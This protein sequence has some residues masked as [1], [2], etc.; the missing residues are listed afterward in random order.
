MPEFTSQMAFKNPFRRTEKQNPTMEN[1]T[2]KNETNTTEEQETATERTAETASA[3]TPSAQLT[4]SETLRAELDLLRAEHQATHDKHLRLFAEFDNFRKRTAKEKLELLQ[5]G[6][7]S[8]LRSILPVLDDLD[9]A[10]VNNDTVQDLAAMREGFR[11]IQQKLQSTLS[12]QGL[13]VLPD[14]KGEFFDTDKHEA[15][16]KAPA[17]TPDL[18]GKVLEVVENGYTLNDKVIRYAKVVVGE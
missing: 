14:P 15:I 17:P 2:V 4:E 6:G 1:E 8:T 16:T 13:K 10:V 7:E 12:A 11:L 18:K 9:R 3:D 5:F